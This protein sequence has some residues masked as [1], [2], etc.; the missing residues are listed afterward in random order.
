MHLLLVQVAKS[1]RHTKLNYVDYLIWYVNSS[2]HVLILGG[3][4]GSY[5]FEEGSLSSTDLAIL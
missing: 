5:E 3:G 2:F 1:C 4:V